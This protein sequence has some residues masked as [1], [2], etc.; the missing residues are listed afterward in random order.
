MAL[1]TLH[2]DGKSV[3]A[4]K[5]VLPEE[6]L[7]WPRTIGFG[8][9]HVVAMFGATFLVP[10]ITGFPPSTTLLFSGL[11]T[12]LFLLITK[13]QLP[14][15]LGSSFAFLAPIGVAVGS[16]GSRGVAL[17][18]IIIVGVT[19]AL[20]GLIVHFSG[21]R[22]IAAL[23]PPV[24]AGTIVALIG[25]NLA[26]AAWGN[27]Q[28]AP[29]TAL[30]T[31][32]AV[33]LATVLFKGMLGRLSILI[34]VVVGYLF[35]LTQGEVDFT[36]VAKAA[37]LGLPEF[38]FPVFDN[39]YLMIYLGFLPVVLALVAENV[40]HVKGVGA[41]IDRDLDKLTGRALLSDGLATT[42]AGSFG[43]SAT[44]TYGEN[45]GVMASTRVFSTAAY[46]VAAITAI[47]LSLSPAVG[48]FLATIP[49]G[50]IGGVATALYGL[51]GVIG[52]RMWI[53]AKVDFSKP[54]N[55]F[56]AAVGLIVA[57]G[58]FVW[59]DGSGQEIFSGIVL[60]TMATLV[61]YHLMNLVGRLRKTDEA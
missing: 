7:S 12:I 49:Q 60:A 16:T 48:V 22:W 17:G 36:E 42:L 19:L 9:Q 34:G 52:F 1:W 40:S 2:G 4:N 27:V 43:G 45:I 39:Q 10:V 25:L 23:M 32:L 31:L 61:V 11:G 21:T 8:M 15:Y 53:D 41:L 30:V 14:S 20:V 18:G 55:Q 13:N 33:V 26:P 58:G 28:A 5:I 29:L 47:L 57:I 44:T 38:T 3:P 35:A 54:K 24:V 50:V 51:I 59:A 56:T 46:W 37:P 6:R